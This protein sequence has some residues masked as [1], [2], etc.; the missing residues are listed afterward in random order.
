MKLHK[1]FLLGWVGVMLFVN[2]Y[3]VHAESTNERMDWFRG[4]KFGMFIHF[5]ATTQG[6]LENNKM[7]PGER[8]EAAVRQFNPVDFDAKEWVRIAK[9]GGIKYVVFTSKHHDGFCKWGSALTDW[10]IMD[11][12]VF[13]RDIVAELEK[14]WYHWMIWGRL[15]YDPELSNERFIGIIQQRFPQ[16]K[17]SDLFTAWQE[18]SM[19][20]PKTTGLHA[21]R[22]ASDR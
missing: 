1:S 12:T 5:G 3:T 8:Y 10:D 19:V 18:A 6:R 4:A 14:H 7:T 13:K 11:Q 2:V 17:A 9:E 15:G 20:Y 16:I 21:G 22:L